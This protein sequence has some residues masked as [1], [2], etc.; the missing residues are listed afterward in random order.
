MRCERGQ[1]PDEARMK[2]YSFPCENVV[3]QIAR[4]NDLDQTTGGDS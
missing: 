3:K 4:I 2:Q 1:V